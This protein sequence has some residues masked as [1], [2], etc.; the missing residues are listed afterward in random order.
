MRLYY[1]RDHTSSNPHLS[2]RVHSAELSGSHSNG[3]GIPEKP[4]SKVNKSRFCTVATLPFEKR[5]WFA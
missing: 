2:L 5:S 3:L 1:P 4:K